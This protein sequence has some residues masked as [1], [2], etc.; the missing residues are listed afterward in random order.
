MSKSIHTTSLK[1]YLISTLEDWSLHSNMVSRATIKPLRTITLTVEPEGKPL[2]ES[3]VI[4]EFLED[5]YPDNKPNLLP[6]DPYLKA[7]TRIWTDFCTSRIIPS[8]HRFLQFQPMSDKEGLAEARNDFVGKWRDFT[9]EMDKDGP[10]FFGSEPSL[11]DFVV[12][13]WV[14]S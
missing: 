11:I 14:V 1:S 6:S 12:A 8:F 7:R 2:F 3:T 13:P 9:Q 4:C 10:F 5:A